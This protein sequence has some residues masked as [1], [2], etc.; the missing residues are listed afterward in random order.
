MIGGLSTWLRSAAVLVL[1]GMSFVTANSGNVHAQEAPATEAAAPAEAPAEGTAVAAPAPTPPTAEEVMGKL[2][3]GIDTIWVM[4]CGLLV[5]FMNLGFGC[6]E[7][8]FCRAKNCVNILSKNFIVD[9]LGPDVRCWR[10]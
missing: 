3:V 8:G 6:V 4:V 5:F 7:S 10:R 1:L 2:S 9:W